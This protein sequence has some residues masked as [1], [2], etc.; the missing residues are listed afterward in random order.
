MFPQPGG[1]GCICTE[2]GGVGDSGRDSREAGTGKTLERQKHFV[3]M[4]SQSVHD[5][6][7]LNSPEAACFP[8]PCGPVRERRSLHFQRWA[9][10][11]SRASGHSRPAA[12]SEAAMPQVGPGPGVLRAALWSRTL[13]LPSRLPWH[14]CS[15]PFTPHLTR[16]FSSSPQAS[17]AP[18]PHPRDCWEPAVGCIVFSAPTENIHGK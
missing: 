17:Q 3:L 2:L 18:R 1:I 11:H 4:P 7:C 8:G 10:G 15:M 13:A 16:G 6:K 12:P 9:P 5:R 14:F